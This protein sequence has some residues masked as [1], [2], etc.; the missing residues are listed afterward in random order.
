MKP[1]HLSEAELQ[2]YAL[3][4]ANCGRG[5]LEHLGLC[6]ACRAEA[7]AYQQLFTTIKEQPKPVFDFDISTLVLAQL[8]EKKPVF[9]ASGF[10]GNVLIAVAIAV[11]GMSLY[12]FRKSLL[13]V[14]GNIS[15]AFMYGIIAATLAVILYRV[16]S[17]Y[18]LYQK[19][20]DT[21]NF[22]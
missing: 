19:K 5:I 11:V 8:P 12:L 7:A 18:K 21:L 20:I 15:A 6:A 4:K 14:M 22:Y 3:D 9:T 2:Q 16:I 1:G 10:W 17:M 13:N